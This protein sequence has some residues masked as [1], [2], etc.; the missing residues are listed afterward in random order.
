[1][2][3]QVHQFK[4]RNGPCILRSTDDRRRFLRDLGIKLLNYSFTKGSSGKEIDCQLEC[5]EHQRIDH[6]YTAQLHEPRIYL[7]TS[8]KCTDTVDS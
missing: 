3:D 8:G 5:D 6:D 2:Q 4:W 7:Y 1:M